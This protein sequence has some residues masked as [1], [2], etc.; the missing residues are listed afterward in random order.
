MTAADADPNTSIAEEFDDNSTTD[1][2][3]AESLSGLYINDN[4]NSAEEGTDIYPVLGNCGTLNHTTFIGGYLAND[5]YTDGSCMGAD[6]NG[7]TNIGVPPVNPLLSEGA[8]LTIG[9]IGL[10][11][12]AAI[13]GRG[14]MLGIGKWAGLMLFR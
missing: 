7:V 12:Q 4:T 1:I 8:F 9:D 3:E 5:A 11:G 14:S 10:A 6:A 13:Q 2:L